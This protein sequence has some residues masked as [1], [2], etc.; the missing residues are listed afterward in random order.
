MLT[1]WYAML[2]VLVCGWRHLYILVSRGAAA[3]G[4]GL[5]PAHGP[6][7]SEKTVRATSSATATAHGSWVLDLEV[8]AL[9]RCRMEAA[10]TPAR[11]RSR[12]S[13]EQSL[14]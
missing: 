3:S 12:D 9:R 2:C 4:A 8:A 7:T 14:R 5:Q 10:A 13:S 1:M 6:L 11:A